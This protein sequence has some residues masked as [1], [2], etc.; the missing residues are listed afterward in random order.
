[1]VDEQCRALLFLPVPEKFP[2]GIFDTGFMC[3]ANMIENPS[4]ICLRLW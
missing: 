1:M 3:P 2:I 4:Q